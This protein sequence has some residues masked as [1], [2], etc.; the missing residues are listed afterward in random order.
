MT[1]ITGLTRAQSKVFQN[2]E[3][4]VEAHHKRRVILGACWL[5]MIEAV[6]QEQTIACKV[7]KTARNPLGS[8]PPVVAACLRPSLLPAGY[9]EIRFVVRP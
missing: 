6:L 9:T 5:P 2:E 3:K 1:R 8:G 4:E 7:K